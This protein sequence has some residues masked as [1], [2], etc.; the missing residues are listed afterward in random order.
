MNTFGLPIVTHPDCPKHLLTSAEI[1]RREA[2]DLPIRV[3]SSVVMIGGKPHVH[4][5]PDYA[6]EIGWIPGQVCTECGQGDEL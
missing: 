3:V 5:D 2:A 6:S 1:G 4:L